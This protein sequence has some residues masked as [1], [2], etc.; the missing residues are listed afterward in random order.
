MTSSFHK[1]Y[2]FYNEHLCKGEALFKV[3]LAGGDYPASFM[4]AAMA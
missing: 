2:I 4:P 3:V 1:I